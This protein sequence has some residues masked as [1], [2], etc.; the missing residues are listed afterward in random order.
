MKTWKRFEIFQNWNIFK[1]EI[2]I[3]TQNWNISKIK[4]FSSIQSLSK[5]LWSQEEE[6]KT[7]SSQ[8][9]YKTKEYE[10][11]TKDWG[12]QGQ[13]D[14]EDKAKEYESQAEEE[15]ERR[16]AEVADGVMVD[17]I[18]ASVFVL[19]ELSFDKCWWWKNYQKHTLSNIS[20]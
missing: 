8:E 17:S 6:S 4:I 10:S 11:Q 5:V 2:F 20:N 16:F 3:S 12:G 1:I 18:A 19:I 9:T 14:K 7:R 15:P 13:G